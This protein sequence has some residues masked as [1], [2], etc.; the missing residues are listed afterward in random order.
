MIEKGG[1]GFL[2]APRFHP[3]MKYAINAR[4]DIG[5]RSVFNLLGPLSNPANANAQL[6]GVYAPTLISPLIH[7]LYKLNCLEAMV[8]HGL[9]GLDEASTIGKT[10]LGWLK[11][12]QIQMMDVMPSNFGIKQASPKAILGG[13]PKANA[14]TTF[15]ILFGK[16]KVS[17]PKK[18]IVLMNA[19]LGIIVGGKVSC[20]KEGMELAQES[21][22]SGRA[23]AKLKTM[24]KMSKGDPSILEKL[25]SCYERLP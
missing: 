12:G 18:D 19:S 3:A 21:L 22:N 7:A 11:E 15:Q 25:E 13:S 2:F 16:S 9:D 5:I 10:R 17:D 8:V 14:K 23:Y 6:L 1:I 4:R 24:V 20:F